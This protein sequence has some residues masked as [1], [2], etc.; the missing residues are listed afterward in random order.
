M[1]T[2]GANSLNLTERGATIFQID[3]YNCDPPKDH[4]QCRES[5][6]LEK[7]GERQG[8]D[9]RDPHTRQ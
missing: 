1:V 2:L 8:N 5:L 7:I 4:D 3:E 6:L 9:P